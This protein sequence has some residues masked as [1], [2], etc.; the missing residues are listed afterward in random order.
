VLGQPIAEPF[1]RAY[2]G[3]GVLAACHD[4][5]WASL[6]QAASDLTA[7]FGSTSVADWKRQIVDEDIRHT[8][9]GIT[10]VPAID[11]QNRPTFQQV[12]Q[13]PVGLC[14]AAPRSA[15]RQTTM[16]GASVLQVKN[17]TPDS[18]DRLTWKWTRGQATVPTDF[19]TPETDTAYDFCIYAGGKLV[20][21]STA[22]AG[23]LCRG[24]ACWRQTA[25]G[26]AFTKNDAEP[27]TLQKLV[28]R[29]GGDGR[30]KVLVKGKGALLALPTLPLQG[31]PIRTQVVNADGQCWEATFT[32]TLRND[33]D[34]LKA[35]SD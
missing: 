13:V 2:C 4:V 3:G 26:W 14:D 16:P 6:G 18:L 34:R 28:L 30:A 11:W 22:P 15:C 23:G 35:K 1:S 24:R 29:A 32:T 9:A 33:S 19:G 10:S 5:L 31:M 27:R 12:V 17:R 8:A 7:E 25:T 21:R 20:S